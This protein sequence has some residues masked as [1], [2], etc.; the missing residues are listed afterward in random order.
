MRKN[1]LQGEK[2]NSLTVTKQLDSMNGRRIYECQCECGKIINVIGRYLKNGDRSSCGC[3]RGLHHRLDLSNKVFGDLKVLC[4]DEKSKLGKGL[5]WICQCSCGNT[6]SILSNSLMS[7]RT[8]SCGCLQLKSV[9]GKHMY[10]EI[11][12]R[13]YNSIISNAKK[14]GISFDLSLDEINTKFLEQNKKCYYTGLD[15]GFLDEILEN[16]NRTNSASVDRI[17]SSKGYSVDNIRL[18]HKDI[19][20]MKNI[21]THNQFIDY[22]NKISDIHSTSD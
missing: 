15:I 16:N 18:V 7:E 4:I 2:F 3:K 19:N 10:R 6:K 5:K 20:K 22:I 9:S 1:I 12:I 13:Y 21:F 14:R 11:P 8:R 17:D